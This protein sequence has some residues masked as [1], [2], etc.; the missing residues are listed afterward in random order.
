[1]VRAHACVEI[2][3]GFFRPEVIGNFPEEEARDFFTN[4]A[5]LRTGN[6]EVDLSEDAWA[7]VWEV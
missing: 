6:G 2:G 3:D 5:L 1:M 4:Q 7:Q